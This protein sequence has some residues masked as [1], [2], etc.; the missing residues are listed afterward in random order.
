MTVLFFVLGGSGILS[1][2]F[3]IPGLFIDVF[4]YCLLQ[5]IPKISLNELNIL[6]AALSPLSL[7]VA[8]V[9]LILKGICYLYKKPINYLIYKLNETE[10]ER[11][12]I[13]NNLYSQFMN[14]LNNNL[15]ITFK[16]FINK[17]HPEDYLRAVSLYD[18]SFNE[19]KDEWWSKH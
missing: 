4:I 14:V 16:E 19:Y 1:F 12:L 17:Y 18:H 10:L 11:F 5:S 3:M 6:I 15:H 8:I 13:K 7:V 2:W 9:W